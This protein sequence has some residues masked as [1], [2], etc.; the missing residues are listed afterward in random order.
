MR[1]VIP[2]TLLSSRLQSIGKVIVNKNTIP[3]LDNFLFEITNGNLTLTASDSETTIRTS[4]DL[5]E[6]DNDCRFT[7]D[8]RMIQD[9]L[10]EIPEQPLEFTIE[11]TSHEITIRYQNGQYNIVSE[12][13]DDYPEFQSLPD[14]CD[15]I[16]VA[17]NLLWSG[18]NRALFATASDDLRPVMNGIFFDIQDK[19]TIV[20]SDGH[21]LVCST[22][23]KVQSSNHGS[24]ILPKKPALI[25]R[26][27]LNRDTNETTI[28][29]TNR[30]AEIRT[31]DY[32]I[33]CR[34]TEGRYPNYSSVIPQDNPNCTVINRNALISALRRVLV[35]ATKT[36]LTKLTFSA[37]ELQI[38]SQDIEFS[39]SAEEKIFCDY[40]GIP[41]S[42]GFK[43]A[44]LL[45]LINIIEGE[46]LVIK[47]ADA[48][49]AG[50]ITPAVDTEEESVLMLL[51][52]MML[53]D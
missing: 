2:S 37:H 48:S 5:I 52:P 49:R 30:N 47:L 18:V 19:L 3:I 44:F 32:I 23:A 8:A 9:A 51:M 26:N 22:L 17:S 12:S 33:N 40:S 43:G 45:E 36:S 27:I 7:L 28:A 38:S 53:N 10:K 42:I 29:Y 14:D 46:D 31:T 11:E 21:K 35:F 41:M 34:L 6:C 15:K 50:I 1:F 25:L 39:K 20:A 4:L 24:L 13:A 16:T